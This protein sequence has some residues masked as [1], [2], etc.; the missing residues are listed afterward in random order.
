MDGTLPLGVISAHF[1]VNDEDCCVEPEPKLSGTQ[2]PNIE[3]TSRL[4]S[5]LPLKELL[6]PLDKKRVR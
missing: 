2:T 1:D 3:P 6:K 5:L 4:K